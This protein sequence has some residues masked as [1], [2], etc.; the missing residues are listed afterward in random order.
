MLEKE[1]YRLQEVADLLRVDRTTIGRW[2]KDGRLAAICP[3][4]KTRGH[5]LV[6]KDQLE[7]FLLEERAID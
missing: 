7:S 4:G 2:I 5:K 3:S 6:S 1:Y